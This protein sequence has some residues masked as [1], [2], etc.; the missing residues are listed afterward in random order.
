MNLTGPANGAAAS[1]AGGSPSFE[2]A[3]TQAPWID[4]RGRMGKYIVQVSSDPDFTRRM[5]REYPRRGTSA[6]S[7][8]IDPRDWSRLDRRLRVDL[9]GGPVTVYWRVLAQ[10]QDRILYTPSEETWTLQLSQ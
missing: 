7:F 9:S 2:W 4:P 3:D 10:D 8:M 6:Q 1:I 5:T